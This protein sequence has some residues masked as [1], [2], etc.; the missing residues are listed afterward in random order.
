LV[1][2]TQPLDGSVVS[3]ARAEGRALFPACFQLVATINLSVFGVIRVA[4]QHRSRVRFGVIP[5]SE[6]SFGT[7]LAARAEVLHDLGLRRFC[8]ATDR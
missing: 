6:N 8:T 5:R 7:Q 3:V 2:A 1:R 4:Q